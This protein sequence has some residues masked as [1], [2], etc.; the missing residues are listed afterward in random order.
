MG[1][2]LRGFTLLKKQLPNFENSYVF[3]TEF[4]HPKPTFWLPSKANFFLGSIIISFL[5]D[6]GYAKAGGGEARDIPRF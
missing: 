2:T 3:A 6:H 5:S 4:L 1:G